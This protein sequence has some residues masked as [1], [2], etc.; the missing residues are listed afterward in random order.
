MS[1]ATVRNAVQVY[2]QNA[3]NNGEISSLSNVYGFPA[4]LTP[5]GD[6]FSNDEAGSQSGSVIFLYIEREVSKGIALMGANP[7]GKMRYYSFVLCC[8]FRS[9]KQ[10][11]Q[12]AGLDNETFLDDLVTSIELSKTALSDG[13]VFAWGEGQGSWRAQDIDI[14]SYYPRPMNSGA[15][16]TQCYSE[17]RVTVVEDI[18]VGS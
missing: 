15:A 12:D 10:L 13:V 18:T 4:K 14:T 1:R 9:M 11:A 17:V 5:E 16:A 3:A 7:G 6:F 2:L 8:Y